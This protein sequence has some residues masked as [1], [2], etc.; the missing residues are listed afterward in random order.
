MKHKE[1]PLWWSIIH[2]FLNPKQW[3]KRVI[4]SWAW[5]Y[6]WAESF[7]DLENYEISQAA[8]TLR[9]TSDKLWDEFNAKYYS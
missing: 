5:S 2:C 4:I 9:K 1:P 6:L 7:E 8:E 3:L